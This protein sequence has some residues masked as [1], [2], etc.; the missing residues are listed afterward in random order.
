MGQMDFPADFVWGA[1]TASYQIEGA[2]DVG[3]R[4][5]S[6][7]DT[8]SH[9]PGKIDKGDT[10]DVAC[11]H[12]HRFAGDVKLMAELGLGAYRFSIAWPRIMPNGVGPVNS[13]GVGFY[14]RLIDCL[15]E[16]GIEPYATL[17]H[18]D[19][20]Q[21][22]HD[23][24]G[25]THPDAA[26][27]FGDY[28]EACFA[29][30]GDR[31]KMWITH[32]E[33]WC[34]AFLGHGI[35]AHA[36]GLVSDS[37][38]YEVGHG[39]LL[40]H[41]EAVTRYR[42]MG[43]GGK[44]GITTNHQAFL[45]EDPNS[46]LDRKAAAHQNDWMNGWFLDPIYFGDYPDYMKRTLPMPEFTPEQSTQVSQPT[47]FMGLNFYSSSRVRFEEGAPLE[48]HQVDV[49]EI[50]HTE[51]GWMV[52][53]N[54]LR[55]TLSY[56]QERWS[57]KEI[58]ITENGCAYDYPLENGRVH[59]VKRVEFLQQYLAAAHAGLTDGAKLKGYFVWSLLDNF[60]WAFGYSKR[61]GIIHVDYATQQRTPKDSAFFYKKLI[62]G[63]SLEP[64][65]AAR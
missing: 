17:F 23:R 57:P 22:L 16:H 64:A 35:G 4:G 49:P 5:R 42:M 63:N 19:Y 41:G 11:D 8:F 45:P 14:N 36:P 3:G 1:A 48:A 40:G 12:Y 2:V 61:F 59:D 27:W 9:T 26:Q 38:P 31:V 21:D 54:T 25:W 47:D 30:F 29:A 65:V 7:W 37:L 13:E 24:G 43:L 60:E 50:E 53:P 62:E 15:L 51:M 32:N 58:Y 20:P 33:P 56:S 55:E 34:Y 18:W 46:E 52:V 28:A 39:L 44:I 10:G 6:V